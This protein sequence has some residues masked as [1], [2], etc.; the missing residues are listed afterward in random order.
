MSLGNGFFSL[1]FHIVAVLFC[2]VSDMYLN[3]SDVLSI[4]IFY[5]ISDSY[6]AISCTCALLQAER[7]KFT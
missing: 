2:I 4:D 3:I 1:K 7:A 5:R 6:T